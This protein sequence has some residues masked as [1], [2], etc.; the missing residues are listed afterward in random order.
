MRL[1]N[2]KNRPYRYDINRPRPGYGHKYTKYKMSLSIMMAL[3]IKQHL[4]H[5]LSSISEKLSNTDAELKKSVAYKKSV[6]FL[7]F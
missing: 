1:K 2:M 6:Y 5:I 7:V 3:C 4:S